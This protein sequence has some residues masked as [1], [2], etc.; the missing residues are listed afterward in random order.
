MLFTH[1]N[2]SLSRFL[3]Q[4]GYGLKLAASSIFLT[5]VFSS[6]GLVHGTMD[7]ADDPMMAVIKPAPANIMILLDDSESMTF[8][9]LTTGYY[10]GRFPDPDKNEQ[11]G[12]AYIFYSPEDH[13]RSVTRERRAGWAT[14]THGVG[15][16]RA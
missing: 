12:F 3:R 10:E 16:G 4:I 13:I 2:G 1:R 9:V 15:C 11:E 6:A 14:A 8:E 5:A 7:L